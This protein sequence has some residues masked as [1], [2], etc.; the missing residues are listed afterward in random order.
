[1]TAKAD[2]TEAEW[3]T[4]IEG[5]PTAG[6][7]VVFAAKGGTFRETLAMGKAYA[8]ARQQHGA[9]ELLDA[10]ASAKP[11]V[12]HT[13]F[14][15]LEEL[16]THGLGQLRDAV[17]VLEQKATA[18]EVDDYRGFV[19]ALAQRVASAHREDGVDVSPA[20]QAAIS[21]IEGALGTTDA[22]S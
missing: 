19:V 9:S 11:H 7:I 2:F 16:K 12:E 6:M 18:Q 21:D 1:M 5:P 22:S 13:H 8:E 3:K 10:V 14:S 20:E 4:V 15:S 17:A